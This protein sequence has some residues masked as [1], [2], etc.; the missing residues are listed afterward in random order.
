MGD[1]ALSGS[2]ATGLAAAAYRLKNGQSVVLSLP[3]AGPDAIARVVEYLHSCRTDAMAGFV[4]APWFQPGTM[5]EATDLLLWT[6]NLKQKR[7]LQDAGRLN[8]VFIGKLRDHDRIASAMDTE[9]KLYRTLVCQQDHSTLTLCDSLARLS[10][11][12]AIVIDA[13]PWGRS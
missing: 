10:R 1:G 5:G 13:T 3:P 9:E 7:R 2:L 8:P 12:F 11:P 4:R 6:R